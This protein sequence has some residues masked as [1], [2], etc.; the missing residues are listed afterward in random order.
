MKTNTIDW[1]YLLVALL[2]SL[3]FL[4][5]LGGV[6]LFDWDE[7]NFAECSREMI[8]RG[9]YLRPQINFEPFWEKPPLFFW[10]QSLSMHLFGIN[11]YAAR[12]PNA[13]CGILTLLVIY[14]LGKNLYDYTFGWLWVLAYM[15]SILPHL[16]FKSGIID[17]FFNLFI[18]LA[19][20]F[21]I[22]SENGPPPQYKNPPSVSNAWRIDKN[23][24]LGGLFSGLAILTK[25]PVG[26]L[27]IGLTWFFKSL[28]FKELSIK[29]TKC[30]IAFS[31]IALTIT[32]FWF[33]VETLK[34]G[35][36]FVKTFIEYNIRLAKTE[37]AGHGGFFG[38]HFVVLFFGCF[39]ASIFALRSL[40]KRYNFTGE[41]VD[42]TRWMKILFWVVLILFSLVQSKIV[43]YSSMCYLP[44]TFLSALTLK[45][46]VDENKVFKALNIS[47]LTIGIFIG[48]LVAA[49]PFI[50][51]NISLLKPL[52]QRDAFALKNLDATVTWAN[53]ES[54]VGIS[55]IISTI[56]S[57]F[58]LKN[59]KTE[60]N[61][62]IKNLK[63]KTKE[64]KLKTLTI[65]LL[66]NL[67][68]IFNSKFLIQKVLRGPQ[69]LF[70]STALFVNLIL[71]VFI[72]KIEGYSQ[73]AAIE[74]YESKTQE[75]CYIQTYDFKSYAHLFYP[76]KRQ[77]TNPKHTDLDW[78][79]RGEVDK[80]TY[81]VAKYGSKSSLDT[82]ATLQYLY[83]KNGFVFYKRR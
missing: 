79:M 42:F 83:E 22:R 57:Y 15:G 82:V 8:L 34:N 54:I 10:L 41:K 2:A 77:P 78:L 81:W 61:L 17:P 23:I 3:F 71:I 49:L 20:G 51:Q 53:W 64:S 16:Y 33:G 46:M 52:L 56:F 35:P 72:N 14:H 28:I 19:L 44:L 80:P 45:T 74:F 26:L 69:V 9:D 40:Y 18:F 58:M 30:F 25:G 63:L 43:H 68:S 27:I 75:D 47:I 24:I 66:A 36:W 12:F 5:F 76:K 59:G 60:S 50:G 62:L 48:L 21:L 37:D 31:L 55:F 13:I 65:N 6:H 67:F 38:Y 32:S 7:I 73:N 1:N 39:P 70:F 4:P 11:E 29:K